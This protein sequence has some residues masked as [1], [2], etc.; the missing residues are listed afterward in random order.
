MGISRVR[1]KASRAFGPRRLHTNTDYIVLASAA[2]LRT[3][4]VLGPSDREEEGEGGRGE[5]T[6]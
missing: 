2:A 5:R 3:P 6:N 1:V 4:L